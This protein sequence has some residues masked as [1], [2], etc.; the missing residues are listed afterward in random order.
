MIRHNA[1]EQEVLAAAARAVPSFSPAVVKRFRA[2]TGKA[3]VYRV[4]GKDADR[5]IVLKL[6][7]P[8]T[9]ALEERVY[10]EV[11]ARLPVPAIRCYGTVPSHDPTRAWL[12]LDHANGVPFD[13]G[14]SAHTTSLARWLGVVHSRTARVATPEGFPDHG[15]EYWRGVIVEARST[16][17]AGVVNPAVMD[18]ERE[19]LIS[20]TDVLDRF[21]ADWSRVTEW[22][23]AV[24]GTLTHGD[25]VPQNLLMD[26]ER[27]PWV[28]DWGAAG[29]GCPMIDLLRVNL[30]AY[31]DSLDPDWS[32]LPVSRAR[33][34]RALGSVCWTAWVLIEERETLSSPWPHRAAAKIPGY[35]LGLTRH[36][37]MEGACAV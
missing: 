19:S 6:D 13:H 20:L 32:Q 28:H 29:W 5:S 4:H 26:P 11:L 21:L 30:R 14:S 8:Q 15:A 10:R 23:A 1:M 25:L 22:M 2:R 27:I 18:Q 7:D 3:D 12:V 31:V 34:L 9:C 37:A 36:D 16:L 33:A 35:L 24:P 17:H